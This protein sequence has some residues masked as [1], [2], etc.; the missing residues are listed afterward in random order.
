MTGSP[1]PGTPSQQSIVLAVKAMRLNA[2]DFVPVG[3]K[4]DIEIGG[5]QTADTPPQQIQEAD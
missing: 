1:P 5:A 2:D 3:H 4:G